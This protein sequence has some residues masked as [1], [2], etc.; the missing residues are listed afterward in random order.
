MVSLF[1]F[2]MQSGVAIYDNIG[3]K[4]SNKL[5]KMPITNFLVIT[6]IWS[7]IVTSSVYVI[8]QITEHRRL[9]KG[10]AGVKNASSN[11][12]KSGIIFI[13]RL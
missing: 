8:K 2:L 9:R 11:E 1:S 3:H 5:L 4:V 7:I 12:G 6:H 13:D 10:K